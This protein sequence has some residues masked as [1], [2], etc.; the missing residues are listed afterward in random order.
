MSHSQ[1]SVTGFLLLGLGLTVIAFSVWSI[2]Q[3]FT[4]TAQPAQIFDLP[5]IGFNFGDI[6]PAQL[7]Q[8]GSKPAEVLSSDTLN[9]YSNLGAHYFLMS[10]IV[11]AGFKLATL[12]AHLLRVIE[13]RP[14]AK[15]SSQE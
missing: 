7:G 1:S 13:F 12:G 5:A 2:Y 6:L 11:N 14:S 4:G 3:V 8:S 15:S 10:F 9:K